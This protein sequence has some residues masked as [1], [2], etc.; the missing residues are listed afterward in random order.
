[1]TNRRPLTDRELEELAEVSDSDEYVSESEDHFSEVSENENSD[2]DNESVTSTV[3]DP[4]VLSKNKNIEWKLKPFQ[5]HGRTTAANVIRNSPGPT[6]YACNRITDIKSAFDVIFTNTVETEIIKMTNIE[7]RQ[8]FKEK[9][10]DLDSNIFQAY[11]GLLLLAGVYRSNGESTKSLWDKE[12][13]RSIFRATMSLETF[14]M[15]S[16]VVRFDEKS[17]RQE[18][19][20][21][22][23]LAAVRN[24]WEKWIEVLPKLYYPNENVT[25][26]E[27]LV[28][29]RGRF[30]FKQYIPSKPAKYGIKIWTLCDS[31]TSYVLKAQIY[32]GKEQGAAPERNQGMRV[33]A[34]LTSELRGHNIT[35]DNFFTSYDLG[36]LLLRRKLTMLG[37]IRK[38]KPELPQQMTNKE[39][40]SSSFYFTEDTTVVNYVPRKYKNVVLM[41]TL[42][43]DNKV[44]DRQDHKPEMILDYNATKG[45]V[46]TLDKCV[47]TYSAK[48]KTNR[49]PMIVFYNILDVSAYNAYVLWKAINPNWH[50]NKLTRRRLFLENLGKELIKQHIAAR[51]HLPRTEESKQIVKKIQE[52]EAEPGPSRVQTTEI[53][54]K[55]ARCK[56]CPSSNDNKTNITCKVCNKHICKVH[57]IYLCPNCNK[58]L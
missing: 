38:N 18:R 24:I 20:R 30:P 2:D 17:T 41:S 25:V 48:R 29:F 43:H 13:G 21:N 50:K 47:N 4:Y 40:H 34:D 53:P 10:C 5:R 16:R 36:Q 12:T 56:F 27:Q 42:H 14:C 35:C 45:A 9:W 57:V 28:A 32:T 39:V 33:V 1:M 6:R 44:S 54:R 49:W 37:T 22:D 52:E 7:G 11:V 19:R 46:D 3:N 31:D 15:I 23:K 26:D 58:S 51:T 8:V 55:R